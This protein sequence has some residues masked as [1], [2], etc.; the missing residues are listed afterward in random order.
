LLLA[1]LL[2]LLLLEH[3]PHGIDIQVAGVRPPRLAIRTTVAARA[4]S[5]VAKSAGA[6]SAASATE[7]ACIAAGTTKAACATESAACACACAGT[8]TATRATNACTAE[9]ACPTAPAT[10]GYLRLADRQDAAEQGSSD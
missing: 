2:A 3:L 6:A 9:A 5:A 4:E 7:A 1:G 10:S 8:G